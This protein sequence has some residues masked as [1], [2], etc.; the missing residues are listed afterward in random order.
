MMADDSNDTSVLFHKNN[1][2]QAYDN[3]CTRIA[4]DSLLGV[5]CKVDS[6]KI[7]RSLFSGAAKLGAEP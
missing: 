4:Y 5:I 3:N 7:G 2:S 6:H 1:N